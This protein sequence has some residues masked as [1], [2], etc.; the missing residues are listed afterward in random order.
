M[1]CAA[2]FG[3]LHLPM[4]IHVLGSAAGGGFPQWN[5]NCANCDGLRRGTIA[6]RARTQSSI[7][8]TQDGR[9]WALV[10]ASPDILAQIRALPALQPARAIRD[11]G[12]ASVLLM[13]AQIDHVT[14]LLM[15]RERSAPLPLYATAQV[16]EDL[17]SGLTLL[18]ALAHYCGTDR[19]VIE[20]GQ[21]FSLPHLPDAELLPIALSSKAPP[22]SPHRHDPHP[23]DNIGLR[24]FDRKSGRQAFYAPGL[25]E[26]APEVEAAMREADVLLVDGTFWREDEMIALGLS[27]KTAAEMGHLPQCGPG[28]MIALLDRM[29][30]ARKILIHINNSNPILREDGAERALL[31]A[32]GIEVA[33]DGMEIDL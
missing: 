28:G 8:L 27:K 10:N 3:R 33:H 5:C 31:A 17:S 16:I 24:I 2:G 1:H 13:D 4:R 14:G 20:P 25:G 23:G 18:K 19:R 9:D 30:A 29:P 21:A 11:T 15:L 26:V 12:I 22:Y 7:A 32:H 6:A